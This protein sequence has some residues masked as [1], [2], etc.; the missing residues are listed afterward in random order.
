MA[1]FRE[2]DEPSFEVT[3]VVLTERART[4]ITPSTWSILKAQPGFWHLVEHR[5]LRILQVGRNQIQLE[6]MSYVGRASLDS[7]D[8]EIREKVS[9]ALAALLKFATHEAFHI[10]RTDAPI[11]QLGE[12]AALLV[13]QF[14]LAVRRY[15][16]MGRDFLYSKQPVISSLSGG[17]LDIVKT[18]SLRA[19]G[20]PHLIAF[21]RQFIDRRT[22]TNR[23]ALAALRET[24]KLA[25]LIQL[26]PDDVAMA[27]GLSVFFEDCRDREIVFGN[28]SHLA[29]LARRLSED[30]RQLQNRDLL[31]LANV[32]LSH[33]SFEHSE[34]L[35][36]TLPRAWFLNL[37]TLFESAIRSIL[38]EL[39]AS[40]FGLQPRGEHR[41]L[42]FEQRK[43]TANPDL[44]ITRGDEVVAIGDLKYKY[45]AVEDWMKKVKAADLYQLLAHAAAFRARISFLIYPDQAFDVCDLGT[46]AT[47]SRTYVFKVDVRALPQSLTRAMEVMRLLPAK[48][49]VA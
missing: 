40:G 5:R 8:L 15:V 34:R 42:I 47:G 39:D 45:L 4:H 27:R 48:D 24:E 44:V 29:D 12:L 37:E 30:P 43:L 38:A 19:R 31:V 41:P 11:T 13:R 14:L 49:G 16:S 10:Q 25:T 36:G 17:R 23:V 46:S 21:D 1:Q 7:V 35:R 20:F 26:N 18:I 9:G 28:R 32:L 2:N 33:V 6:A 22:P 3:H